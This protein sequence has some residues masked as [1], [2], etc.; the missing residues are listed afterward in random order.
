[1]Y[2]MPTTGID[3]VFLLCQKIAFEKQLTVVIM[4]SLPDRYLDLFHGSLLL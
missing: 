1:M 2:I 3:M 4:R